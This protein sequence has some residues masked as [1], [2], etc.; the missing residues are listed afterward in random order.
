MSWQPDG[1]VSALLFRRLTI[2]HTSNGDEHQH[3]NQEIRQRDPPAKEQHI[4]QVSTCTQAA[5]WQKEGLFISSNYSNQRIII[6]F[7][8]RKHSLCI[9]SVLMSSNNRDIQTC[10][11]MSSVLRALLLKIMSAIRI[12]NNAFLYFVITLGTLINNRVK[13]KK[14]TNNNLKKT[15]L[16]Y[17]LF[18]SWLCTWLWLHSVEFRVELFH[19]LRPVFKWTLRHVTLPFSE[20][21]LSHG[22][23]LKSVGS[24]RSKAWT[25]DQAEEP[26]TRAQKHFPLLTL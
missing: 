12:R 9:K 26:L 5:W 13:D 6:L 11:S 7:C 23:K 3:A 14:A 18:S 17:I 22:R 16:Y 21:K 2:W 15:I 1:R 8:S 19:D 10:I 24:F 20:T 4:S 25:V